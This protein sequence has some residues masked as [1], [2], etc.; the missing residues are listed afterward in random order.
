MELHEIRK[1]NLE[2][3]CDKYGRNIVASRCGY[4]DTRYINVVLTRDSKTKIGN[5]VAR[6][7]EL[8]FP[9]ISQTIGWINSPQWP[10]VDGREQLRRE[11]DL[12][13]EEK[14]AETIRVLKALNQSYVE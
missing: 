13:P 9:E 4:A 5:A 12:I 6:K 8:A 11:V 2:W 7:I 1:K 14:L 3:L 10:G